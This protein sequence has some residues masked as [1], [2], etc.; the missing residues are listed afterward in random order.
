MDR[1]LKATVATP[2]PVYG[3]IPN[4]NLTFMQRGPIVGQIVFPAKPILQKHT[5]QSTAFN[6][7]PEPATVSLVAEH[8]RTIE[9]PLEHQRRASSL[10][11]IQPRVKSISATPQKTKPNHWKRSV[12]IPSSKRGLINKAQCGALPVECIAEPL[13]ENGI[14]IDCIFTTMRPTD[15]YLARC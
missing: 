4:L 14:L 9:R 1:V 15:P 13:F 11:A 8:F 2:G 3:Q 7:D 12:A 10:D 6:D 5:H